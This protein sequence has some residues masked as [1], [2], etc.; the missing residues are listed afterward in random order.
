M[1]DTSSSRL[2][3]STA[4]DEEDANEAESSDEKADLDIVVET[5]QGALLF[6]CT[7]AHRDL[8]IDTIATFNNTEDALNDNYDTTTRYPGPN[9][10][11]IEGAV[12]ELLYKFLGERGITEELLDALP[13]HASYVEQ[14]EYVEWIRAVQH[15]TSG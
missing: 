7:V 11:T 2:S 9:F 12:P 4:S 8:V 3:A 10:N 15:V 1:H 14:K 5:R 6:R 13:P